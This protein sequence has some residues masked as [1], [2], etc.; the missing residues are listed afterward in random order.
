MWMGYHDFILCIFD[1]IGKFKFDQKEPNEREFGSCDCSPEKPT[2][3][4]V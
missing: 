2:H 4:R 1:F 3:E